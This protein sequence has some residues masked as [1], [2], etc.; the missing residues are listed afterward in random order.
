MT[1]NR[2]V[3]LRGSVKNLISLAEKYSLPEPT[4]LVYDKSIG[5]LYYSM[6]EVFW[7]SCPRSV[8]L[9]PTTI[10]AISNFIEF[11]SSELIDLDYDQLEAK[12]L[13]VLME[14]IG[15]HQKKTRGGA[16]PPPSPQPIREPHQPRSGRRALRLTRL[17]TRVRLADVPTIRPITS[18]LRCQIRS[19]TF[20]EIFMRRVLCELSPYHSTGTV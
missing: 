15:Y 7:K 2:V 14:K 19:S 5:W 17:I 12:I 18:H 9:A 11:N 8:L 6:S 4:L 10:W 3:A 1:E 13:S 20:L 16:S